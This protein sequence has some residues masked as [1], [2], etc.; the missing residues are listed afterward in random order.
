MANPVLFG[1]TNVHY[2]VWDDEHNTYG[3]PKRIQGGVKCALTRNGN[4]STFYAD[5]GPYFVL[6]T[7]GGYTLAVDLATI[8]LEMQQDVMGYTKDANGMVV[9]TTRDKSKTFAFL[10]E[11]EGNIEDQRFAFYN[12]TLSRPES[13][14]NTSTDQTD[15]DTQS[16][17]ITAIGREF[18]YAETNE[19]KSVVKGV[20]TKKSGTTDANYDNFFNAVLIPADAALTKPSV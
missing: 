12:C 13:E 14:H 8:P 2:A 20:I 10:Y 9:E 6:E 5:N 19:Y 15:P 11:V 1:F 7:N 4:S 3:T 16:A 17:N 18:W